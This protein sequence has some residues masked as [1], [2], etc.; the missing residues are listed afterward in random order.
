MFGIFLRIAGHNPVQFVS[1]KILGDAGQV[2]FPDKTVGELFHY[3]KFR[4]VG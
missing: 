1:G 2:L 3:R 4:V